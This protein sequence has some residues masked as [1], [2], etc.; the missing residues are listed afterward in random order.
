MRFLSLPKI[1]PEIDS[2]F[3]RFL[4]P[5]SFQNRSK[6]HQNSIQKSMLFSIPCSDRFLIDF[7][8]LR[9]L[10]MVI[11]YRR[12]AIFHKIAVSEKLFKNDQILIQKASRNRSKID[13]KSY[14]K[15]HQHLHRILID[16]YLHISP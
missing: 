1:D 13:Q 15:S 2:D 12:G 9:N 11:S 16:F 14:Q 5:K 8:S 10:K 3:D 7:R 6:I 4:E